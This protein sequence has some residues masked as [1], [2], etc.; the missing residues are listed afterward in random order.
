MKGG[1]T[2]FGVN[3]T[4]LRLDQVMPVG[5]PAAGSESPVDPGRPVQGALSSVGCMKTDFRMVAA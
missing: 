2:N 1:L 4:R 3:L 5:C